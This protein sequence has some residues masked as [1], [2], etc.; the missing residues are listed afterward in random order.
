[1]GAGRWGKNHIHTLSDLGSLGG[2]VEP[3]VARLD[4]IKLV[5]PN[6]KLFVNIESAIN[7]GFDGFIVSTPS[8][9]HFDIAKAYALMKA[10]KKK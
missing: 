8:S 3:N 5:Y 9:L 6:I 10:L 4:E 7:Y 1:M 2:V